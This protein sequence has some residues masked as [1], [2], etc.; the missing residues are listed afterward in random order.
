M[1]YKWPFLVGVI[2]VLLALG[3]Y[4]QFDMRYPDYG[5]RDWLSYWSFS[6][7]V[8]LGKGYSNLEW[9]RE[10]QLSLGWDRVYV[11]KHYY[12]VQKLW[13]PPPLIVLLLPLASLPFT[14]STLTWLGLSTLFYI[15][16]ATRFNRYLPHPLPEAAVIAVAL[17]F[18]PFLAAMFHGQMGPMLGA[19]LIYAW[20][21][22]RRG[23][24]LAAG[25]LL[26]PLMLKPH[27][28][29]VAVS[30]IFLVALRRRQWGVF[31][32]FSGMLGALL[33]FLFALEPNWLQ[34]WRG[35]GAPIAWQTLSLLDMIHTGFA[36]PEWVKI[37]GLP[38]GVA[39]AVWRYRHVQ[40]ITPYLLAEASLLS[41]LL[42]P[43]IWP[44]DLSVLLAPGL[45]LASWNW[46]V[47]ATRLLFLS[48][49][50]LNLWPT[51]LITNS[52]PRYL[53]YLTCFLI[54]W[55]WANRES[56]RESKPAEYELTGRAH[57]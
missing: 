20:H 24:T 26:V 9:L 11:G 18:L 45:W 30:L 15:H 37:I 49:I 54:W 48:Q 3:A 41:I 13:N 43:Y 57:A 16:A 10:T 14:A 40:V 27:L 19:L 51:L 42:S 29:F 22:Q 17:L 36:L 55:T 44:H 4:Y 52:L 6:R 23:H 2:I 34:A 47:L 31:V 39:L 38:L 21:A 7:G 53:V 1:R 56:A 33:I 8:L 50:V 12:P 5:T 28:L 32:S 35:Q 46:R 25:T